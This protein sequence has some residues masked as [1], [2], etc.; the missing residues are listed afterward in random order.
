MTNYLN[1]IIIAVLALFI[2]FRLVKNRNSQS[3]ITTLIQQGKSLFL[4]DVRQPEEFKQGSAKG[5]INIPL[6]QIQNRIKELKGKENIVVFC[7]SGMRAGQAV[8]I[9]KQNGILG[10]VNGGSWQN[11]AKAA[12]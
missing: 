8:A 10:V 12:E 2:V 7:K 5:A 1:Y 11:V 4:V 6:G 3:Q 9:L